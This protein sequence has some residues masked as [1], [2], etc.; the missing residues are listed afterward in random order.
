MKLIH[1]H[2]SSLMDAALKYKKEGG[3]ER[4]SLINMWNL[5]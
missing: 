3:K 4:K 1:V 2:E 5:F